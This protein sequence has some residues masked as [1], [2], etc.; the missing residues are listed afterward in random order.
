MI[1]NILSFWQRFIFEMTFVLKSD[2]WQY[3]SPYQQTKY[4]QTLKLLPSV[5]I[6][7]A[8]ELGC[9]E[10]YL[11]AALA[12]RVD[13]LVAADISQIA[14]NRA[15][16]HCTARGIKNVN[17]LRLDL[18]SDPLPSGCQLIICSEVLYY[19]SGQKTLQA[20]ARKLADALSP[21]GYLLTAH[22]LRVKQEP[23]RTQFDWLLPFG[24]NLISHTLTSTYPLQLLKE[25]RAPRYR[26]QLFQHQCEAVIAL[27]HHLPEVIELPQSSLPALEHRVLFDLSLAF[28]YNKLQPLHKKF[29]RVPSQSSTRASSVSPALQRISE[30]MH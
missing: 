28:F 26:L 12:A 10:G 4:Q 9:A 7:Q 15:S 30:H 16:Q 3:R 27:P 1:S 23:E 14:L 29:D 22:A 21:G 11:T 19:V 5:P 13:S 18:V 2:P 8:L 6:R 25:I 24:A 20:V 17:F